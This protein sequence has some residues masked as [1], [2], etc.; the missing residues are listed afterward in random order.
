MAEH[1]CVQL[2]P[3]FSELGSEQLDTIESI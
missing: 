3:I 1:E 2:V